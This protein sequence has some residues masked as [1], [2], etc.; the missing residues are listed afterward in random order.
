MTFLE[1]TITTLPAIAVTHLRS[2]GLGRGTRTNQFHFFWM[3]PQHR[4]PGLQL[5][6][7]E[8]ILKSCNLFIYPDHSI[9]SGGGGV[10]SLTQDRRTLASTRPVINV[11]RAIIMNRCQ[12][13]QGS[14]EKQDTLNQT[15]QNDEQARSPRQQY[16]Q[17]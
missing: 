7:D 12:V 13:H 3:C 9:R 10:V 1:V 11:L 2:Q 14:Y 4:L 8:G 15:G 6:T 16:R 5:Q 17:L